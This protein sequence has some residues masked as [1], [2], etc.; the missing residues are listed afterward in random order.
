MCECDL[1]LVT[2]YLGSSFVI[3]RHEGEV[4]CMCECDL[5]LVRKFSGISVVIIRHE[6][7]GD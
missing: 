5:E 4:R 2:E 1:D 7:E 3:I 6:G